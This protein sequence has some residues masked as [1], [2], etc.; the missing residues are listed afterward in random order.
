LEL[1]AA[2]QIRVEV[3]TYSLGE[4]P[5]AYRRLAE[6]RVRGRAVVVPD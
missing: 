3:E 4:A 6:G 5:V 2:G 1:A